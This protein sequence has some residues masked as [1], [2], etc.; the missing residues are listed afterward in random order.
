MDIDAVHPF[1][2]APLE[3][4]VCPKC[5][6]GSLSYGVPV[7]PVPREVEPYRQ[8]C[9]KAKC[10][11]CK[12]QWYVCRQCTNLRQLICDKGKLQKH[13][14][15]F[16]RE[17]AT[18][19][20]AQSSR[21]GYRT[22]EARKVARRSPT[23]S[24]P[25]D[26]FH[27]STTNIDREK[28][29]RSG[30][31]SGYPRDVDTTAMD[32]GEESNGD[33]PSR[34][35]GG[36]PTVISDCN[37]RRIE[38]TEYFA[39]NYH[40]K[41]GLAYLVS[42]A[43]Y[44]G[45]KVPEDFSE[46]DLDIFMKLSF[47]VNTLASSQADL[48]GDFLQLLFRRIDKIDNQWKQ[49]EE[50]YKSMTTYCR[51]CS[52][53]TCTTKRNGQKSS[54]SAINQLPIFIPNIPRNKW[55]I[56][57][58]LYDG[59]RSLFTILPHPSIRRMDDPL[60]EHAYVLPSECI[61]HFLAQGVS[62]MEFNNTVLKF[63][64]QKYNQTPRGI[65]IAKT[66]NLV[67]NGKVATRRHFNL[68][69]LE[70][71]D[72]CESAK[73]NRASKY[74]LW[75]FTIT[76]FREERKRD[77]AD[78]TYVVAIGPKGKS[79][80]CVE[81]II[82]DDIIRMRTT[83]ING[84]F[85]W[86]KSRRPFPCTFSADLFASLGDQPE[87]RGG[88]VLQ[89]GNS[90]CHARWRYACNVSKLATVLP[91]CGDCMD[92]MIDCDSFIARN[93]PT[94]DKTVWRKIDC[95]KCSNWMFNLDHPLL[96]FPRSPDFPSEYLLGAVQGNGPLTPIELTHDV[97]MR[98]MK[99][100][101]SKV[102]IGEWR[103]TQGIKY[104]CDNCV[105]EKYARVAMTRAANR[106]MIDKAKADEGVATE[107]DA[108]AE[109]AIQ[110]AQR[111][112]PLYIPSLYT[113][114][115][116]LRAFVDTPMH[117]IHL[118]V[119]KSIF[120]RIM[121][122][123]SACGRKKVFLSIAKNLMEDLNALKLPWI[124]LLPGTIK[125]KWGGWVSKH[126]ASLIR[127]ALWVFAPLMTID[128]SEQYTDP[129]GDPKKWTV[130]Q[131]QAWLKARKLESKGKRVDLEKR[132]LSYYNSDEP[133][134]P[135]V[136]MEYCTAFEM[137]DMLRSFVVLVS[138][139][140][141]DKVE[142]DTREQLEIRIRIFL[143]KF[144]AFDEPMRR[145]DIEPTWIRS[146]NFM[147][148]LN[149]PETIA[150][151]GPPRLWFEG[152]WL[153]EKYVSKVKD[154][155]K[156]CPPFNVHAILMRNLQRRKSVEFLAGCTDREDLI[157][158]ELTQNTK[159]Y[160]SDDE[161]TGTFISRMPFPIVLLANGVVG[162]LYYTSAKKSTKQLR[163]H[164]INRHDIEGPEKI[165]HGIVYWRFELT[166]QTVEFNFESVL[167]YGVLLRQHGSS[168]QGLYT[169]VLKKWSTEMFG[170]YEFVNRDH[171]TD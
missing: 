151:F 117:L 59:R 37:F 159:I 52:C 53:R 154:E 109:D 54:S 102:S 20:R 97:L 149:L 113:R 85:G 122:W 148:L 157:E 27:M 21:R 18:R 29:N 34:Q 30:M 158:D 89:L 133:L 110:N 125:D 138:T 28:R 71:K 86:S 140:F 96:E 74:P 121:A 44:D 144:A 101:F 129:I 155:R 80:D 116:P 156:K 99:L 68:S 51:S 114:G 32:L 107:A 61:Q 167:D 26:E 3:M 79:H 19:Q 166:E 69:F 90:R 104:L 13:A 105:S 168:T 163:V 95:S 12:F 39:Q 35:Y 11:R 33:T 50:E 139:I 41:N 14:Y 128:D 2:E 87:R 81:K 170:R 38:S 137:L 112:E 57:A 70:W 160:E 153:G 171:G 46:E 47:L 24:P 72:D 75:V 25:N 111:F 141:Q 126:Y 100:A 7:L 150:E 65:A 78:C 136:P 1:G 88:N 60:D 130:K 4:R 62:P 135:I 92:T 124:V 8:W 6:H 42:E 84:F 36:I 40:S 5:D 165:Q 142:A 161:L 23:S 106:W 83:A 108:L 162:S 118:G 94:F 43:F 56:R 147:C 143:T 49:K 169:I 98:V 45:N 15:H 66:L 93:D 77:S 115:V 31:P 48:L 16:H 123:A 91:A 55:E 119:G 67:K 131:Y 127:V 17:K 76:I 120:F 10:Q 22:G 164:L 145:T 152:K 132:V 146:Y 58:K 134:P 9:T 73:S 64:I 82:K 63:P 103:K